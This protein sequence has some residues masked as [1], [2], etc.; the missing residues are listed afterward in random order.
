MKH[1]YKT[2]FLFLLIPTLIF[3]NSELKGKYTKTKTI[4]KEFSVSASATVNLDNKYGSIDIQTWDQNKVTL[5]IIITTKSNNESKAQNKLD[6][7]HI[8]FENSNSRV[9]AKTKIGK[10]SGW[11]WNNNNNVNMDIQYIVRMPQSNNLVVDMDYG[12]VMID[13]LEGKT[14]INLDYGKLIAGEF[15]NTS[16]KINMDYSQGS[17]ID[18][19][20]NGNI[21][22]DY[23]TIEIDKAGNIDLVADYST[24][25]IQQANDISFNLDYGNLTINSAHSIEGNSD[26][27][28]LKFGKIADILVVKGDYGGL[29]VDEMGANFSR[30]NIETQYIGVK[31]GVNSNSSFKFF[32]NTQYGDVKVPSRMNIT[33]HLEK[34]T[35]TEIEGTYNGTKGEMKIN[36]QYGSIKI[37]EN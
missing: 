2:V 25:T 21:N 28:Q 22:T 9:V 18:F 16:N 14:D 1:I 6:D 10:S 23:S 8:E 31:I 19:L 35:R 3:A 26:Y 33:N 17:S 36:T 5:E 27:T 32:S 11:S 24:I 4:K 12:D 7:I 37:T 15:L 34:N 30:V 29:K 20:K 13:K